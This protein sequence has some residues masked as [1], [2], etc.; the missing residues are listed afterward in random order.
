M[1]R[2]RLGLAVLAAGLY[3]GVAWGGAMAR[4][5]AQ[6]TAPSGIVVN[7]STTVALGLVCMFLAIAAAYGA[8]MATVRAHL[9]DDD[10]HHT[11]GQ[12]MACYVT[13]DACHVIRDADRRL[14][15]ALEALTMALK[16]LGRQ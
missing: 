7:E 3:I 16:V 11:S 12:M 8:G 6:D 4:A 5:Y 10:I 2:H 1:W 9:S 13:R 14:T 15:E